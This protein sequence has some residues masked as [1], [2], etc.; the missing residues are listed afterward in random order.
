MFERAT[1]FSAVFIFIV[2]GIIGLKYYQ[3]IEHKNQV[4]IAQL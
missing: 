1:I 4:A 2:F 3:F